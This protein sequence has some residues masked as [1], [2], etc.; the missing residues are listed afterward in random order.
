MRGALSAITQGPRHVHTVQ[1]TVFSIVTPFAETRARQVA[2]ATSCERRWSIPT[3]SH[4]SV[5]MAKS[6]LAQP[7]IVRGRRTFLVETPFRRF[8]DWRSAERFAAAL[9]W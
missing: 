2:A 5:L 6:T 3:K 7:L 4:N 9:P 8:E 1:R